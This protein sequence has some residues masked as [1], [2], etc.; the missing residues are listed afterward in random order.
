MSASDENPYQSPVN[1]PDDLVS[2]VLPRIPDACPHCRK[3]LFS[4]A[5]KRP[6][7]QLSWLTL[8]L[9]GI[10]ALITVY[11]YWWCIANLPEGHYPI[12]IVGVGILIVSLIP[13]MPI[14]FLGWKCPRIA[15][16]SCTS[17]GWRKRLHIRAR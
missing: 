9:I 10:S 17:C 6:D 14:A 1:T 12:L 15:T 13:T 7:P 5:R 11:L 2:G 4:L 3:P 16:V 8:L